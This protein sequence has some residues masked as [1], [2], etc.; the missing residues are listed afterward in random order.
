MGDTEAVC[1]SHFAW[2]S[3]VAALHASVSD[4][5]RFLEKQQ[6]TT[7]GLG[8]YGRNAERKLL[9][10]KTGSLSLW[11]PDGPESLRTQERFLHSAILP[12]HITR[13]DPQAGW[14][15][16]LTR[17]PCPPQDL[18]AEKGSPRAKGGRLGCGLPWDTGARECGAI[19]P[20]LCDHSTL[21]RKAMKTSQV[22]AWAPCG[23]CVFSFLRACLYC[24]FTVLASPLRPSP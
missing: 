20:M 12:S 6:S 19:R 23:Q 21:S 22:S 7:G 11:P 3:A 15:A 24:L 9:T 17:T 4:L 1:P 10:S 16:L 14:G 5:S 2:V 18:G 13:Q 8:C